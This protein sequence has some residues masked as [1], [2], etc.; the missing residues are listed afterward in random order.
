[1]TTG[2]SPFYVQTQIYRN[3][4]FKQPIEGSKSSDNSIQKKPL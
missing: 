1:M 3:I 4:F 2:L